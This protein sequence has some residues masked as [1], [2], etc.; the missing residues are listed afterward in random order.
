MPVV[1]RAVARLLVAAPDYEGGLLYLDLGEFAHHVV[2]LMR[3]GA[4]T[5][6]PAIFEAVERLHVDGDAQ[7][8]EAA[9][10]GLLDGIQNIAGHAGVPAQSF[11]PH[12][13]PESAKWWVELNNF[14]EGKAPYVGAGVKP[15]P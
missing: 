2:E 14:W 9:T 8:K 12:L 15:A 5:E 10:I 7:V 4:T 3:T 1:S 6:F 13:K 11:A